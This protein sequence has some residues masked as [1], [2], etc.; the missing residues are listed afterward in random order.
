MSNNIN[1]F[2][3]LTLLISLLCCCNLFALP[4][5]PSL[6]VTAIAQGPLVDC[7]N[8]PGIQGVL[9]S[10][11]PTYTTTW[12]YLVSINLN[13]IAESDVEKYTISYSATSNKCAELCS[14]CFVSPYSIQ[15]GDSFDEI[16]N[17]YAFTNGCLDITFETFNC[18]EPGEIGHAEH[19]LQFTMYYKDNN[20]LKSISAFD[21]GIDVITNTVPAPG[22]F[23]LTMLS[24]SSVA[25]LR[26]KRIFS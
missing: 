23:I 24:T 4:S 16:G 14:T 18:F 2:V 19:K 15:L 3:I 25:Y 1:R 7:P 26:R 17:A 13:G 8:H 5:Q 12:N 22:A 21:T 11:C 9:S 20:V 10:Y 6:S